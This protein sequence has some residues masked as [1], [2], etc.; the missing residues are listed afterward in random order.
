[1]GRSPDANGLP[2]GLD[3]DHD[4]LVAWLIIANNNGSSSAQV[5]AV[6]VCVSA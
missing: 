2:L 4:A 3:D 1:L 6:G 5:I